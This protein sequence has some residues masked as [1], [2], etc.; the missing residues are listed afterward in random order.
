M[1]RL[2]SHY[3]E[4][5]HVDLVQMDE[6]PTLSIATITHRIPASVIFYYLKFTVA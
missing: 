5:E 1:N 2:G 3:E 4:F 6:W